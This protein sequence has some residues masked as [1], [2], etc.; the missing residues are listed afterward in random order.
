MTKILNKK[1]P[2]IYIKL[3]F[4]P[5]CGRTDRHNSLSIKTGHHFHLGKKCNGRIEIYEYYMSIQYD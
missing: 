3:K 4:C 2:P 5:I 1:Q